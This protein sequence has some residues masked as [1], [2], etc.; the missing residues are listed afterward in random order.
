M[1][2]LTNRNTLI[3]LG[4]FFGFLI[5]RLPFRSEFLINWDAAQF[6][7]ATRTFDLQH[8]QPH[9]PGYIGYIVLGR[10]LNFFTGDANASFTLLSAIGGGVA[11]AALFV[12]GRSF[13]SNRYAVITAILFGLSPILWYYS[14]VALTYTVEVAVA[15][16]FVWACYVGRTKGSVRHLILA[17]VLLA[18]LGSFRQ[19]GMVFLLPLWLFTVWSFPRPYK[20]R[21]GATLA[22]VSLLWLV[23]LLWLS[24]GP[25]VYIRESAALAALAGGQTSL[26]SGRLPGLA[27]NVLF[28]VVGILLG[29]NIGLAIIGLAYRRGIRPLAALKSRDRLFFILWA[30]PATVSFLAIHTGQL[31][32]VLLILPPLFLWMG[33]SIEGF[34]LRSDGRAV[35]ANQARFLTRYSRVAAIVGVLALANILGFMY[36]PKAIH[37]A[38]Q[39][40]GMDPVRMII[41]QVE[42]NAYGVGG[43]TRQYN[44]DVSDNYWKQITTRLKEFDSGNTVIFTASVGGGSFRQLSHYL[45]EY[46]IYGIGYGLDGTYGHLFTSYDNQSDYGI[47]GMEDV[48]DVMELPEDVTRIIIPD[49]SVFEGLHFTMDYETEEMDDGSSLVIVDVSPGAVFVFGSNPDGDTLIFPLPAAR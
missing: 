33:A 42:G 41:A 35:L 37:A 32:Y 18:L 22:G 3:F 1:R 2:Y 38:A 34:Q 23:P 47:E 44:V 25:W 8:H 29:L 6:A 45:P 43:R 36:L 40:G 5:L 9:P 27:Q 48:D 20:I 49:R 28:V 26:L 19:T 16:P 15:L 13:M 14:S 11:P 12:L 46:R 30:A 24:G 39:P 17:S 4:L 7:M 10:M 21:A 31:G